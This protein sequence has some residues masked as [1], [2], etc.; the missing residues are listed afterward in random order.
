MASDNS[1]IFI[2]GNSRS[3]STMLS[4]ILNRNTNVYSFRELHFFDELLS[5]HLKET[6]YPAVLAKLFATEEYICWNRDKKYREYLE[7]AKN[8][9]REFEPASSYDL[10][11][12]FTRYFSEQKA[13]SHLVE[14]T[15]KNI[16]FVDLIEKQISK[17][18]F[19]SVIR[20]PQDV[21]L[22]QKYKWRRYLNGGNSTK[23]ETMRLFFTYNPIIHS[24]IYKRTINQANS[25]EEK[26]NFYKIRFEDILSNPEKEIR[27]ICS[28]LRLSFHKDMLLIKHQSSSFEIK[29]GVGITVDRKYNWLKGGLNKTEIFINQRINKDIILK[30]KYKTVDV[31]PNILI[32]I[33]YFVILP[34]QLLFLMILDRK[35]IG[36]ILKILSKVKFW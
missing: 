19:I 18:T 33:F 11:T 27:E 24:I 14:Q 13:V 28:F 36:G 22:S 10:Y 23:R 35:K 4:N 26:E 6:D 7:L 9:I 3:G 32:L 5:D 17:P 2:V 30:E 25:Y 16:F 1:N 31:V 29:E 8:L 20:N 12:I 21:L 15:P 34:L